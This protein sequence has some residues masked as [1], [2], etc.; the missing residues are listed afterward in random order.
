[1]KIFI[2]GHNGF[3]GSWM[4]LAL[5]NAGHKLWGYAR[6]PHPVGLFAQAHLEDLYEAETV[7]DINDKQKLT[8]AL[9]DSRADVVIHLAA[10]ALVRYGYEHPYETYATNVL[11]TQT[12]LEAVSEQKTVRQA[13]ITTTDKVYLPSQSLTR[14]KETSKLGGADPYSVSKTAA[15]LVVLSFRTHGMRPRLN[16]VVTRC[17][18]VVG[19][20][21]TAQDRLM[22]DI[23]HSLARKKRP[24]IRNPQHVRVWQHALDV[25]RAYMRIIE[26]RKSAKGAYNIAPSDRVVFTVGDAADVVCDAWSLGASWSHKRSSKH[27][28][29]ESPH[30]R[31]DTTKIHRELG[32][33][34]VLSQRESLIWT[35]NWYR[36]VWRDGKDARGAMEQQQDM[37]Q[38][39]MKAAS[40]DL[41]IA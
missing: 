5:S 40:E 1:M 8:R 10:Q 12:V 11:G 25:S 23:A 13:I 6:A 19:G 15:E 22:F 36:D 30:I 20:G 34:N 38:E 32:W 16:V 27:T 9:A 28:A 21:D 37:H 14:H 2:T 3:I 18:N 24:K 7:A 39:Q 31:L 26:K 41:L 35:A 17:G 4:S 33:S 29:P